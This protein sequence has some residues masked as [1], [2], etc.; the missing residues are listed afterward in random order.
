MIK[1]STASYIA[2]TVFLTAITGFLFGFDTAIISGALKFIMRDLSINDTDIVLQEYIVSAVPFGALTGAIFSKP[3]S[4]LIGR[5]FSIL[6]TAAFFFLGTVI[7]VTSNSV[8]ILII[9]RFFIG[10][11]VGLSSM[12]VP[13]YLSEISPSSIRGRLVFCYQLAGTIGLLAAFITNYV[14]SSSENWRCMFLVGLFPSLLL[15]FGIFIL[16]ESPH[17]LV[18][19]RKYSEAK[20]VITKIRCDSPLADKQLEEIKSVDISQTTFLKLL[21]KPVGPITF[22]CVL[23]FAL[24]QLSGINIIM[25]YSPTIY[26]KAGFTET[27]QQLLASLLN[28]L[29]FV[30]ATVVGTWI[31]DRVGRKKL[32]FIGSVG[33]LCFLIVL[34]TIYNGAFDYYPLRSRMFLAIFAILGHIAFF[35]ISLGPI[36]YLIMSELFPLRIKESGMALVSC[37][38]WSFNLVV[39][40]SFLSI[41]NSLTIAYTFYFYA[42]CTFL[43][44]IF[45]FFFMPETKDISLEQIEKNIFSGNKSR[46]IGT[47]N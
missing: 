18:I 4:L 31:V 3:S 25:Y 9:G 43:G 7:A 40:T 10:I 22:L 11:G 34:G 32:F 44:I 14:F 17:F 26:Q 5:R 1:Y 35:A 21:L 36:P 47:N 33:M 29:V 13:M 23:L 2:R 41:V 15:L 42:F 39:S 46:F 30:I 8:D 27:N 19:K 38:N 24:Q 16:P 20:R 37:S 6:V 28:G 45:V 12:I